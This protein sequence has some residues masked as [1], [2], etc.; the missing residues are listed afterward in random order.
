MQMGHFN[1]GMA[2]GIVNRAFCYFAAM[3]MSDGDA[4]RHSR[5]GCRKNLETVT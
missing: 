2:N 4:V 1:N 3:D 5:L